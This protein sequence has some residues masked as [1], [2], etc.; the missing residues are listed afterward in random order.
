MRSEAASTAFLIFMLVAGFMAVAGCQQT[1]SRL[2]WSFAR[3]SG[4][5]ASSRLSRMDP[6]W[7]I[8]IWSLCA[9]A[10]VIFLIGCIY[11]GSSTAFNAFIGTGLILQLITFAI[12]AA[13]LLATGRPAR[14][15]PQTRTFGLPKAF[16]W[17]ANFFTVGYALLCVVFYDLPAVRPVTGSNM[18]K[19]IDASSPTFGINF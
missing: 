5:I 1:A 7:Q 17:V 9:N 4:L 16:G 8:P 19:S 15:L 18:S 6:D 13:L 2:T 3:D 14:F 12:P 10:F 11:L